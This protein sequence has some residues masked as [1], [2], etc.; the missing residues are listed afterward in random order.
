MQRRLRSPHAAC[1]VPGE[2]CAVKECRVASGDL[3]RRVSCAWGLRSTQVPPL[4]AALVFRLPL[5]LAWGNYHLCFALS[6]AVLQVTYKPT[7]D[8]A[9]RPQVMLTIADG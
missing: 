5:H 6:V 7:G 3:S 4:V 8:K 9:D 1:K 2:R